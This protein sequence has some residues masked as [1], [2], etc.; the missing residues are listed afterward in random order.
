[1]E[2]II[3]ESEPIYTKSR[4][5]L[6]FELALEDLIRAADQLRPTLTSRDRAAS[7]EQAGA[8]R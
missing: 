3:K 2:V 5:P 4:A 7:A 8:A 6:F 1:M